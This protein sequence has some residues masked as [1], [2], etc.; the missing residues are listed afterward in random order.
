MEDVVVVNEHDEIIGSMPREEAH[1]IGAPHRIAV[2]Y[3]TNSK[4]QIL[5]QVRIGGRFDHS[6]AGH[7]NVGEEYIDAAQRELKE[8]LGIEGA[9]L[10]FVGGDVS[11]EILSDDTVHRVHRMHIFS[12]TGVPGELQKEEV[13]GV[14][15]VDPHEVFDDMRANPDSTKWSGGFRTSLPVFLSS[16]D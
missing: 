5:V 8:E 9:E 3:V 7:V 14:L 10:K 6:S 1:R 12:C 4:G 16:L 11:D 2:T 15:W 13:E